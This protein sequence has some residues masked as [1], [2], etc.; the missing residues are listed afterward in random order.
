MLKPR[1][2]AASNYASQLRVTLQS[3]RDRRVSGKFR[4]HWE[5]SLS[6]SR[7]GHVT[8]PPTIPAQHFMLHRN[9]YWRSRISWELFRIQGCLLCTL[10]TPLC[11]KYVSP[12]HTTFRNKSSFLACWSRS[13]RQFVSMNEGEK[14]VFL[15]QS[16]GSNLSSRNIRG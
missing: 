11:A 4:Y 7:Y 2:V 8:T 9:W 13:M 6:G 12:L 1:C 15:Q 16:S 5:L 3:I 14:H 10:N